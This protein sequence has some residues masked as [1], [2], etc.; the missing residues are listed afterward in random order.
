MK[1]D[2]NLPI[3]TLKD[4]IHPTETLGSTLANELAFKAKGMDPIKAFKIACE[5]ANK[6]VVEMDL[7]DLKQIEQLIKYSERMTTLV[8]GQLLIELDKQGRGN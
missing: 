8:Q 4:G 7:A 1:I 3:K 6:K 2:L 5:F